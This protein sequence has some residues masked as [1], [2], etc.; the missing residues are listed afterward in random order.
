MSA[1]S[2]ARLAFGQDVEFTR[3]L[4]R[5]GKQE[6]RQ[7]SHGRTICPW[8]KRWESEHYPGQPEPEPTR[9]IVVGTRF[10]ANGALGGGSWDEP[11]SFTTEER[12]RAYLIAYD[13]HRKPVLVLPEH[14]TVITPSQNDTEN[15]RDVTEAAAY[16]SEAP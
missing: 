14:I 15:G 4:V 8:V 16:E 11:V 9:G 3:T 1:D 6:S 5:R 10:L 13:L 2:G 12:F 7:D